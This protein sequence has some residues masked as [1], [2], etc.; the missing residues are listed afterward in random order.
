MVLHISVSART[1]AGN[2]NPTKN[3][4]EEGQGP[5]ENVTAYRES[6]CLRLSI[7][8]QRHSTDFPRDSDGGSRA[9]V[10]LNLYSFL[11]V[12]IFKYY[13][14]LLSVPQCRVAVTI[15]Q[16]PLQKNG[17]WPNL[18]QHGPGL[19][20]APVRVQVLQANTFLCL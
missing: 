10:L 14:T 7:C 6:W 16:S 4:G 9:R 20:R 2:P 12:G 1:F 13:Q 15:R 5:A 19:R 11:F 8:K 18:A 17:K 3:K